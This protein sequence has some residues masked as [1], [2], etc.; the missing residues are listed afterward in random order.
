[1]RVYSV[2][3]NMPGYMPNSGPYLDTSKRRALDYG[4]EEIGAYVDYVSDLV[5]SCMRSCE[6]AQISHLFERLEEELCKDWRRNGY[7]EI[8]VD[9]LSLDVLEMPRAEYDEYVNNPM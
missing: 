8:G 3:R 4:D 1:M 5:S 6:Y 9:V 2:V 7:V